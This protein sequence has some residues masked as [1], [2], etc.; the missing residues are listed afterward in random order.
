[1]ELTVLATPLLTV[2][3]ATT[4]CSNAHSSRQAHATGK[5]A[6]SHKKQIIQSMQS[7]QESRR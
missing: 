1:L 4:N 7:R 6:S 3:K 5:L 2:I